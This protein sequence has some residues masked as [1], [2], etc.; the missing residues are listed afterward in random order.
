M[1]PQLEL[2]P[3]AQAAL[4]GSHQ[5]VTSDLVT[6]C[7]AHMFLWQVSSRSVM[8]V[9]R[10]TNFEPGDSVDSI[11]D[12]HTQQRRRLFPGPLIWERG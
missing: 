1:P 12:V 8:A 10:R 11:R 2:D 5:P 3:S 9:H 4:G 7:S 6:T